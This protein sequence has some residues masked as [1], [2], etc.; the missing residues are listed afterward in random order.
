MSKPINNILIVG[1]GTAGWLTAAYLA[2]KLGAAEPGG[3]EITLIESEEVPTIGVGEGTFP[4]LRLTLATIGVDEAEF[5]RESTAAFKQGISFVNWVETPEEGRRERYFHPFNSPRELGRGID[6]SPYWLL[7]QPNGRPSFADSVTLQE[8]VFDAGRGPKRLTDEM[9][10]GPMNYGYHLDAGKLAKY[11][12]KVSKRLGVK[13]I[14]DHVDKVNVDERGHITSLETRKSGAQKAGL[15]IDCTGFAGLLIGKTLGASFRGI[16]HQLFV[17]RAVT[18]PIPHDRD[19]A[20]IACATISTAHE[21]GWSWDIGLC[22][23]RGIG[24][25]YSSD[26]TD[27]SRAEEVLRNYIGPAAE[28]RSANHLKMRIGYRETPWV[29]NCVAVGLSGGFLEPLEST[30]IVMIEAAAHLIAD[31]FPRHGDFESTSRLFNRALRE[32]Y[33]CAVEFIKLHFY[34]SKR[35]DTDFWRDNTNPKSAP[36]GLLEKLERWKHHTPTKYDLDSI[37]ESFQYFNY[38]YILYGMKSFPEMGN[39]A[40]F[41]HRAAAA[42]EFKSVQE[43]SKRALAALPDHRSL[44]RDVYEQGFSAR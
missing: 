1:G 30:G 22:D 6:L 3:V 40:V 42:Q 36:D 26:H 43:A 28:G 35:R 27:D 29:N 25:V 37:H 10:S 20:S 16:D 8:K 13:H 34:L 31:Y 24:Y 17:D 18:M 39:E 9:Y 19:D 38:Q 12:A 7:D 21:A 32:R 23:R 2:R 4:S 11:L 33:E 41:S 15:Y 14:T 5:M 44:L